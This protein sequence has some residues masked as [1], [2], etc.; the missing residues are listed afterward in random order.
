V[1]YAFPQLDSKTRFQTYNIVARTLL[2]NGHSVTPDIEDDSDAVLFSACDAL[3]MVQLRQLMKKTDKP[4]ILVALMLSTFGLQVRSQIL[5]GLVRCSSLRNSKRLL[6][7]P[8]I[9]A[10]TLAL[11]NSY[12]QASG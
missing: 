4:I 5:S 10:L 12:S 1:K 8:T 7:L 11:P 9:A 6:T 3:D 2:T